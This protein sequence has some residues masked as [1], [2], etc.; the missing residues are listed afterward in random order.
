VSY[1]SSDLDFENRTLMVFVS[2]FWA[3]MGGGH[4]S[5]KKIKNK[6]ENYILNPII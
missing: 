4:G 6:T 1:D 2:V 3:M 5:T